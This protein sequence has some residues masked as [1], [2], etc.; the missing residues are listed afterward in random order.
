MRGCGPV[1]QRPFPVPF[2]VKAQ[3]VA[4]RRGWLLSWKFET[5]RSMV[6]RQVV[7]CGRCRAS[8]YMFSFAGADHVLCR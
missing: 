2:L 6:F 8:W 3:E 5:K 1:A 7:V 4:P